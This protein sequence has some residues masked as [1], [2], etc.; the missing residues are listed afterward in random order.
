MTD[1]INSLLVING[2]FS[3]ANT[4]VNELIKQIQRYGILG[5]Q[6]GIDRNGNATSVDAKYISPEFDSAASESY[7]RAYPQR[8][9]QHQ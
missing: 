9:F 5:L 8:Y 4:N 7:K 1:V 2:D 3:T 6:S